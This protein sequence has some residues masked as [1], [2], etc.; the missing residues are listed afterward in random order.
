MRAFDLWLVERQNP[1]R[2]MRSKGDFGNAL[3][4]EY[5]PLAELHH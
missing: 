3:D 2:F 1:L 4:A 5:L